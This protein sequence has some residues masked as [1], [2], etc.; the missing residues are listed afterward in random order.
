MIEVLFIQGA[1]EGAHQADAT[2]AASLAGQLGPDYQLRY[3]RMPREED[4]E[5]SAWAS[6]FS[7]ELAASAPPLLIVG[8]SLGASFALRYLALNDVEPKPLGVFLAAAPFI[9]EQGWQGDFELPKQAGTRLRQLSLFFFQ[10]TAD[11]VVPPAHLRLY[12]KTFP[13]ARFQSLPGR[14]HQLDD[15]MTEL[16]A[17]I[18]STGSRG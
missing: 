13:C 9:G 7:K 6:A 4:P 2:L 1:S 3:P 15:D 17:A 11:E 10:G 12:E 14:N 16:A 5:Y 18:R 8:H